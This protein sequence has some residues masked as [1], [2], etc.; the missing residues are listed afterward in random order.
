MTE[1]GTVP[2]VVDGERFQTWY[3]IDGQL[4]TDAPPPLILL[5][6]GPGG[7][8]DYLTPLAELASDGFPVVFYDQL[9]NGNSTH[10][11]RAR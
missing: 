2:F 3:R 11:R 6:G 7:T 5:H 4:R 9:G 10:L 8:H 1:S